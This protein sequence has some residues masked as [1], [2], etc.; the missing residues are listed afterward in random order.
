METHQLTGSAAKKRM[1]A[2]LI[3]ATLLCQTVPVFA[4]KSDRDKPI[5]YSAS[6][7]DG[8]ETDRA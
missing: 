3:A 6:S 7:L 2:A 1:G 4:E 5:R 8:N